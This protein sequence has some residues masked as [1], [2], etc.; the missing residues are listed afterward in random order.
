MK[1]YHEV[2][3]VGHPGIARTLALLLR[4]FDW[5]SIRKDVISFVSS[6]DSCQRV[7]ASCQR[8]A[9][10]LRPLPIP[11]RPWST[12]GMDMIVK[13]PVSSG[14]AS[15]LVFIDLLSKAT[16]FV[17]VKEAMSAKELVWLFCR[18]IIQLHGLPDRVVSDRGPTFTS[19]YWLKFLRLS[20][21]LSATSTA[22][23]PQTDGQTEQMNQVLEDYL[24]HFVS[25]NQMD[26]SDKLDLAEFSL[27]NLHSSSSGVSPFFFV[28][29]YHPRFNTLTS[30]PGKSLVD[31]LIT[32]IQ[33]TQ[34]QAVL[35]LRRAQ[36]TQITQ[37]NKH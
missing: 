4:R 3:I 9:G 8:P 1:A 35:S 36:Q 11:P 2:P 33:Q 27:N 20:Q 5:P 7:K 28:H 13:L 18:E 32:S 6:C 25:Y 24:C 19:D 37:A 34:D 10:S 14:Y 22:Y 16:H 15:I 23:H 29:G 26:W 21:I 30:A 12:V 31:D 17:P